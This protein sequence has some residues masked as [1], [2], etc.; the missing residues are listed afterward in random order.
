MKKKARCRVA[1]KC[2][3]VKLKMMKAVEVEREGSDSNIDRDQDLLPL[4]EQVK[5]EWEEKIWKKKEKAMLQE[6]K[7][8]RIKKRQMLCC[9]FVLKPSSGA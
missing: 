4:L 5:V 7:Q 9:Y 2:K 3:E 1:E 8:R 6:Q